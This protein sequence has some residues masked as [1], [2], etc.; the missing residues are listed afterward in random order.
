MNRRLMMGQQNKGFELVYNSSS[1]TLPT[2]QGWKFEY[3][4]YGQVH[5]KYGIQTMENNV[6]NVCVGHVYENCSYVI[7]DK[8]IAKNCEISV[9]VD[10]TI[11]LTV[12]SRMGILLTDGEKA[13]E[14]VFRPISGYLLLTNN[15]NDIY[16]G[17]KWRT[18]LGTQTSFTLKARLENGVVSVWLNDK[19]MTTIS[20]L[21]DVS[22]IYTGIT[23]TNAGN[24][25]YSG[26]AF[27][28]A[29]V[30]NSVAFATEGTYLVT[31]LTYKEW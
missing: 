6:L 13:I 12:S 16:I 11:G 27:L 3:W 17:F 2:E 9:T 20:D 15:A 28:F 4:I 14:L 18:Y 30:R 23:H 22:E 10:N 8:P 21:Y 31:Q 29:N 7:A 25:L 1:G 26:G 5:N 24:P 19:L